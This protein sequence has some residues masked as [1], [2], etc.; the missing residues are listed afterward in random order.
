[1]PKNKFVC[2]QRLF[3]FKTILTLLV[4]SIISFKALAAD[5][6]PP[7]TVLEKNPT[8][9]TGNNDWYREPVKITI[10]GTDLESGVK[11]IFYRVDSG[12]WVKKDFSNSVNLA[13]NPSFETP[14]AN[15]PLDTQ[16]WK[17]SN[18]N[19]GAVYSRD[20]LVYMSSFANTSIKINSSEDSWHSVDHYDMFAASNS[21][22]NMSAYAWIKTLNISGSAYFNVYSI[23]QSGTGPKTVNFVKSSPVVTGTNDWTK[24]STNFTP[25]S[26][27]V[28][29]IYLEIGFLGTGTIWIDAVNISKSDIPTTAFYVS[30][31]GNHTVD[32]YAV[33]KAGNIETTKS[34]SFKI[35]QTPPGNWKDSGAVRS[36]L[37]NAHQLYMW[38]N[39]E[40]KT[41]GLS[42]F[43]DK[44]QYFIPGKSTGFGR[45]PLLGSC[46]GN[47]QSGGWGILVSPPFSPGVKEAYLITPM[48][49]FCN[50]EWHKACHYVRFYAE[51]MA[52]NSS[53]RD[54]CINGPWI[55][56]RGEG[57][58]R[59]NQNIDMIAEVPSGEYNTDGLIEVGEHSINFF[60]S[61]KNIAYYEAEVPEEYD[62]Q[63][64]FDT[65]RGEKTQISTSGNLI[66]S[67]GIYYINGNYEISG[68]KIPSNYSTSVF[69]QIVFVN[70][71]LTISSNIAV[72]KQST[73]LFIVKGNVNIDEDVTAVS[74][75][76]ISDQTI[77]TA[78]NFSD[79]GKRNSI[80]IKGILIANKVAF[81]RSLQGT[82]NKKFPAE[83]ITYEPKYVLKMSDYIGNNTVKWV[84]SD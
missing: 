19:P 74:V 2:S 73:T 46:S 37:G 4:I 65:V 63:K 5:N 59:A 61:S 29:G 35:D 49:D 76:L 38:T 9:P 78:Y 41:S 18:S 24:I 71:N 83:D 8:N 15:P 1:M 70:G 43:T 33:D 14:Y 22:N 51:D 25:T 3:S 53:T 16:D 13:P 67:S 50:S 21:F 32:Y 45:Y 36:L 64:F 54:M 52:G 11:E 23:S 6:T 30:T 75:G 58:V 39:V 34:G 60:N 26:D 80:E 62:Y 79:K 47:W 10:T 12:S 42:V 66:S 55:R 81:K 57:I 27:N 31:D 44:F 84:Y 69:N 7:V 20:T 17:I 48:V 82:G 28:I 77:D 68:N 40:D 56:V 72:S